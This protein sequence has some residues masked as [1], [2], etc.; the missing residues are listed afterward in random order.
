MS[1]VHRHTKPGLQ[2]EGYGRM[3]TLL[4]MNLLARPSQKVG[5]IFMKRVVG[6]NA[7]ILLYEVL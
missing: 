1:Q 3:E 5:N 7:H 6:S 2:G 4:F